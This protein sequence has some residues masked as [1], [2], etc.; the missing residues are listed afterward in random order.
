MKNV[1]HL[2]APGRQPIEEQDQIP[3]RGILDVA[4]VSM[5][6]ADADGLLKYANHA[7]ARMIG[8]AVEDC[9]GMA[10]EEFIH[11]ED[12]TLLSLQLHCLQRGETYHHYSECRVCS[13]DGRALWAGVSA[14]LLNDPDRSSPE[15][16]LQFIDISRQ[17]HAESILSEGEGR[18]SYALD[19]ARQGVWD[20]DLRAGTAYYSRMWREMRGIGPTEHVDSSME[21]WLSNVHPDDRER[22]RILATQQNKGEIGYNIMEYRERHRDGHYIW[23]LSRGKP[24]EWKADGDVL[25]ML[26]TDTDISSLKATEARLAEEKERFRITLHSIGD[27]V[28]ST[29]MTGLITFM[30]PV[31]E[32]MTGWQVDEAIGRELKEVFVIASDEITDIGETSAILHLIKNG[33]LA[34]KEAFL[35][36]RYGARTAVRLTSSPVLDTDGQIV[37]LV[38]VFQDVTEH[39]EIQRQLAHSASHDALTGLPNRTA[40]EQTLETAINTARSDGRCHVLCLTDLDKFKIVNDTAGHA[41]GDALLKQVA[42][43]FRTTLRTAD[44]VARIG[45]DEFAIVLF[46]CSIENAQLICNKLVSAMADIDFRWNEKRFRIGVSIGMRTIDK[47]CGHVTDLKEQADNACYLAKQAGGGC[48]VAETGERDRVVASAKS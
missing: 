43:T 39:R 25:R 5:A 31:A 37:G 15:T 33:S 40:F 19:A 22:L 9:S 47:D 2:S 21:A 12:V 18:L 34:A 20:L 38:L 13:V 45:G 30:N 35:S 16:I 41:A 46:D 6:V 14:V 28:I 11:P 23:I 44:F 42:D 36:H 1:A 32:T 3:S 8:R 24:I 4:A 17:K 10:L 29:D 7:L 48:A 26:G 27:G